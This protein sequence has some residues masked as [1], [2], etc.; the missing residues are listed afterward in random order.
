M[1]TVLRAGYQ[2]FLSEIAF[3]RPLRN[4]EKSEEPESIVS[5]KN[6]I[7]SLK[8]IT[9]IT[10][11]VNFFIDIVLSLRSWAS[12]KLSK[13]GLFP[14]LTDTINSAALNFQ[15]V[16]QVSCCICQQQRQEKCFQYF[17][18]HS[19]KGT[20]STIKPLGWNI[21]CQNRSAPPLN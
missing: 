14:A 12:G 8:Q 19:M 11:K 16:P 1:S 5:H 17:V 21:I 9:S 7:I 10:K 13:P 2:S 6:T 20:R 4:V 3:L 18:I 15:C